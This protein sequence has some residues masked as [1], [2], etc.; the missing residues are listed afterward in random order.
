M[1][2][3]STALLLFLIAASLAAAD[4]PMVIAHRGGSA[5]RPENTL[6]AFQHALRIGVSMLEFDM[7]LTSDGRIIIHHDSTVNAK[8]CKA[9]EGSGVTARPIG[10]MTL[11]LFR[12][13]LFLVVRR[14]TRQFGWR[15]PPFGA[16]EM[17]HLEFSQLHGAKANGSHVWSCHGHVMAAP[18]STGFP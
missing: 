8:I 4:R 11:L 12:K 7:N 14:W 9:P 13:G 3:T 1:P 6:P 10:L 15:E 17:Q 16:F 18:E 2:R 5:S